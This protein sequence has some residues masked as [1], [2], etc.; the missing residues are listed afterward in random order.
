VRRIDHAMV[1][2]GVP[3]HLDRARMFAAALALGGEAAALAACASD[4]LA[5]S[6]RVA[7]ARL[8]D[9]GEHPHP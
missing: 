2:A 1:R 9:A 8:P 6:C 5:R 4:D 3:V 7:L